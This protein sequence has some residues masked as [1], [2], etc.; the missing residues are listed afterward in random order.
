MRRFINAIAF[1]ATIGLSACGSDG[2]VSGGIPAPA[3]P[4]GS[5]GTLD[6]DEASAQAQ[7]LDP[8]I[9]PSSLVN[10]NWSGAP[11][12]ARPYAAS[13]QLDAAAPAASGRV[14]TQSYHLNDDGGQAGINLTPAAGS[15]VA[16]TAT[17]DV[18]TPGS[19]IQLP[20]PPAGETMG[21]YLYA[22]TTKGANDACIEIGTSYYRLPGSLSTAAYVYLYDFC[23]GPGSTVNVDGTFLT[24]YVTPASR[25]RNAHYQMEILE[26]TT[27]SPPTW[28]GRLY[29]VKS[30][31]W[32]TLYSTTGSYNGW[33]GRGWTMYETH[34]FATNSTPVQCPKSLPTIGASSV[35]M[36]AANGAGINFN[37]SNSSVYTPD[38]GETSFGAWGGCFNANAGPNGSTE[39]ASENFSLLTANTAWSVASTGK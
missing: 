24:N 1:F 5:L 2:S 29:N 14:T 37:N 22:P 16:L 32:D 28:L 31:V 35:R 9:R 18:L 39:A 8:A 7:S 3:S 36:I 10:T 30:H 23:G 12:P 4:G 34:F 38:P 17:H 20:V 13:G 21:N 26:V 25:G 27:T 11:A 19:G 6:S 33:N 15:Y